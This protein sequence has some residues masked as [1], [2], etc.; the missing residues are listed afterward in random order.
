VLVHRWKDDRGTTCTTHFL[1]DARGSFHVD[2]IP[3]GAGT[4]ECDGKSIPIVVRER[5]TTRVSL[6]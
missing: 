4:I 1:V 3:A 6:R 5:E 2:G